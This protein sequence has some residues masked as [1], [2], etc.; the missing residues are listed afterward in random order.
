MVRN[1]PQGVSAERFRL[2][3]RDMKRKGQDHT[4]AMQRC[5]AAQMSALA[6]RGQMEDAQQVFADMLRTR[7]TPNTIHY[8]ILIHGYGKIHKYGGFLQGERD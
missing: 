8:N 4:N 1:E 5:F 3:V 2:I 6:R 7:V